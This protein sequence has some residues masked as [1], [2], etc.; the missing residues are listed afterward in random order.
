MTHSNSITWRYLPLGEA[1]LL[2]EGTPATPLANRYVL[3]LADQLAARDLPGVG[4][5]VPAINSLLVPFDPL[6]ITFEAV[7]E[8]LEA[9]LDHT[10]PAPETP[11]RVVQL[12]V[13]FG[14]AHGPDLDD[15]AAGCGLAPQAVVELLCGA[16]LRVMMVGFAPGYPY[17]GPLPEQLHLPRR[18][19]PRTAVPPGSVAI[20]AGLAG[21][22]PARLPGG[23]HLVGRTDA[24]LFDP[25]TVPPALLLA[26]DGVQFVPVID[27][28][29]A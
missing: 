2:L 1:A 12:P 27:E 17:I 24:R 26:G 15:V 16:V 25:H 4:A 9:L 29:Q 22:Y 8:H 21:I 28:A 13:R 20:A 6:C 10:A 14:G 7:R 3:A 11:T 19:T 23:W 18:A 5:A